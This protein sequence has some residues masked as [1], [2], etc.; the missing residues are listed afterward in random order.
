MAGVFCRCKNSFVFVKKRMIKKFFTSRNTDITDELRDHYENLVDDFVRAGSSRTEARRRAQVEFGDRECIIQELAALHPFISRTRLLLLLLCSGYIAT[1]V[2]VAAVTQLGGATLASVRAEFFLLW[3]VFIGIVS[4]VL[5]GALW[6][7][8]VLGFSSPRV[9]WYVLLFSALASFSTTT[10]LDIDNFEV[11]LHVIFFLLLAGSILHV[12]M[13]VWSFRATT[14]MLCIAVAVVMFAA[15][16]EQL[17]FSFIGTARCLF[18]KSPALPLHGALAQCK[19]ISL[20]SRIIFPVILLMFA[21]VP[22]M[23]LFAIRY[24][25]QHTIPIARK[26]LLTGMLTSFFVIPF[27]V[28]GMNSHGTLDIIPEKPAIHH[29]YMRVLGRA[30]EEKDYAFYATTRAYE[31]LDRIEYTLFQSHERVLKIYLITNSAVGR[32]PSAEELASYAERHLSI[33]KIQKEL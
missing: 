8:Q 25:R 20:R 28:R 29:I 4:F 18:L 26:V 3:L 14:I 21:G 22:N 19:Q 6:M 1:F 31:H 2:S 33:K 13:R 10:V 11:T 17:L 9:V 12:G 5:C 27:F 23:I 15:L 30:P 32:D 24:W 16:R 7:I